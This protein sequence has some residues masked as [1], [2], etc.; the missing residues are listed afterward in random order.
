MCTAPDRPD[1]A[2]EPQVRITFSTAFI[3]R[4]AVRAEIRTQNVVQREAMH[5]PDGFLSP[6]IWSALDVCAVGSLAGC[7]ARLRNVPEDVPPRMGMLGAFVF[8][9]QLV[10][11][12]IAA[13][14]SGHLIGGVLV[15]SLLG[16]S[17]ATVVIAA[18]LIVQCLLFQDGG[19]LALGANLVNMGLTGTIGGYALLAL[20][21]RVVPRDVALFAAGWASVMA[22]AALIS[23][24]L[25]AS[26]TAPL[27][28]SLVAMLGIHAVVGL[29]EGAVTVAVVRFVAR[30]RPEL[31]A[32]TVLEG[33]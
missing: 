15:A 13:G 25:W 3:A 6:P 32:G 2:A 21:R 8:A 31:I 22:S 18:V 17:A 33:R 16:P 24:E 20:G 12:P 27:A 9:A 29:L 1:A 10:N 28:S 7:L 26:G 23:V 11:V 14:T 5:L 30:M 4:R 19:I